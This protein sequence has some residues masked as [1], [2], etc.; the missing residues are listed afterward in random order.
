MAYFPILQVTNKP[1]QSWSEGLSDALKHI[2]DDWVFYIQDDMWVN[3]PVNLLSRLEYLNVVDGVKRMT[4]APNSKYYTLDE[5]NYWTQESEYLLSHQPAIW[6]K[7]LLQW[8]VDGF[9]ET[10]WENELR[11]TERMRKFDVTKK[12]LLDPTDWFYHV[13]RKGNLTKEGQQLMKN[14]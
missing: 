8:C 10:P 3:T 4:I 2:D 11:G 5:G 12:L 6:D 14:L 1:G 13:C 9:K 7:Q